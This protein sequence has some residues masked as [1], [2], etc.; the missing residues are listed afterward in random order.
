MLNGKAVAWMSIV[1]G[2]AVAAYSA[3][4]NVPPPDPPAVRILNRSCTGCHDLRAVETNALDREGWGNLVN[5]MVQKG[6]QV[7]PEEVPVLVQH[8]VEHHGPLPD[9]PGK[10][11]ML[12][13]CTQCHTLERIR[14]RTMS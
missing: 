9:G 8:L 10:V 1:L 4:Q 6:A 12:N 5:S 11:I 13:V 14:T 7:A 3:G 2:S